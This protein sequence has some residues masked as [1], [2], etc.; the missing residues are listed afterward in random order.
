[1]EI[2]WTDRVRNEVL[3]RVKEKMNILHKVT[4]RKA[5]CFGH[6]LRRTSFQTTLLKDR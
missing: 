1:M 5:K 4:R 3:Q 2:S 6:I